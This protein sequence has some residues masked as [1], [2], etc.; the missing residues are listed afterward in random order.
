MSYSTD[1]KDGFYRTAYYID[2]LLKGAKAADIPFEQAANIKFVV[3]V[4][5]ADTLGI[6]LPQSILLQA[7]EMIR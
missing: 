4:K 7:E 1:V 5:T 3:N 6:S 2:R